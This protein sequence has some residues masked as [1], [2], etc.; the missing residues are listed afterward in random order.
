MDLG[1]SRAKT[2][3][4]DGVT[5]RAVKSDGRSRSRIEQQLEPKERVGP[6]RRVG[7]QKPSLSY[8]MPPRIPCDPA[9]PFNLHRTSGNR[10]TDRELELALE[11]PQIDPFLPRAGPVCR[12]P[13][14]GQHSRHVSF[15][16][17]PLP[18]RSGSKHVAD[19]EETHVGHVLSPVAFHQPHQPGKKAPPQVALCAGERIGQAHALG[20][21]RRRRRQGQHLQ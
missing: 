4:D 5:G 7:L 2:R 9:G 21:V 19:L 17:G 15:F 1:R 16:S 6:G 12:L 11:I 8:D 20:P 14:A 18:G 3:S 10:Q 13:P